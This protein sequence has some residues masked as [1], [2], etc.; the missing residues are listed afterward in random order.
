VTSSTATSGGNISSDGGGPITSRGV[1]WGTSP[2]PTITL[3]TKTTDGSGN[4]TYTSSITGLEA[5]TTYFLRAYAE[6]S[7]GVAYGN[8]IVFTTDVTGLT[9]TILGG[10]GID[11]MIHPNPVAENLNLVIKST[12]SGAAFIRIT[13]LAG[14][15]LLSSQLEIFPG[16]CKVRQDATSLAPGT[17]LTEIQIEGKSIVH[18]FRKI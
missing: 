6:N 9:Q 5:S 4:G 18:K 15:E 8:E 17:Y 14:K 3:S 10:K 1:C 16:E 12:R 7:A 13:D 2:G 11:F